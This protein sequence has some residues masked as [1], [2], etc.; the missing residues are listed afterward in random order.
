MVVCY[1][2]RYGAWLSRL[3]SG[4]CIILELTVT[5][6]LTNDVTLH[7]QYRGSD[8]LVDYGLQEASGEDDMGA[9]R[10]VFGKEDPAIVKEKMRLEE[11]RIKK[12]AASETNSVQPE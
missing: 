3:G 5:A 4:E 1:L 12:K 9:W 8:P 11:L 6:D 2:L 10:R 7:L